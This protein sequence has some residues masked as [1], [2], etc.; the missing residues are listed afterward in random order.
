MDAKRLKLFSSFGE[1]FVALGSSRQ[2]RDVQTSLRSGCSRSFSIFSSNA[3]KFT[4]PGGKVTVRCV[5][6]VISKSGR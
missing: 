6:L 3:I 1:V 4:P 5:I 2:E